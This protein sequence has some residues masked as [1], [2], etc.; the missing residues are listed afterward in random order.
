MLSTTPS[1]LTLWV[2]GIKEAIRPRKKKNY[3]GSSQD[4]ESI[5]G[6]DTASTRGTRIIA[7]SGDIRKKMEASGGGGGAYERHCSTVLIVKGPDKCEIH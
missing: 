1:R 3:N 6:G 7:P 5:T 4:Q 2:L